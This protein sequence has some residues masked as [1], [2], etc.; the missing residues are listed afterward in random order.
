MSPGKIQ[1]KDILFKR[2]RKC[3]AEKIRRKSVFFRFLFGYISLSVFTVSLVTVILYNI[4]SYNSIQEIDGFCLKMLSQ[5]RY[6]TDFIWS[7]ASSFGYSMFYDNTISHAMYT[8]D[9][10]LITQFIADRKITQAFAANSLIDSMYIYNGHSNRYLSSLT[11]ALDEKD[12]FDRGIVNYIKR[13]STNKTFEL[14]PR[15]AVFH[16]YNQEIERNLIT[17]LFR[18]NA[19]L[20]GRL[21]GALILNISSDKFN[22]FIQSTNPDKNNT[23]FI[24]NKEGK[25]IYHTDPKFFLSDFSERDYIKKIIGSGSQEGSFIQA[26]DGVESI[27]CYVYL[28]H[29]D[30]W[31]VSNIPKTVALAHVMSTRNTSIIIAVFI[32]FTLI[33]LEFILTRKL[34][35]PVQDL[36]NIIHDKIDIVAKQKTRISKTNDLEFLSNA[37]SDIFNK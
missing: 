9:F 25:I 2:T 26:V 7:W 19:F 8:E 33:A 14:I 12:F 1:A 36:V 30:W 32:L 24:F 35:S 23:I 34:Y 37:F 20:D 6:S 10:D 3:A 18:R 5:T 27:I 4:F 29:L 15:K 17:L 22:E 28:D 11:S 21:T 13:G 16:L 31:F